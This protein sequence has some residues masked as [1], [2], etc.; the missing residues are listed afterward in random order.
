ML[1]VAEKK[2]KLRESWV[3]K[4][5]RQERKTREKVKRREGEEVKTDLLIGK[6][7]EKELS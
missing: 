2:E 3:R 4:G 1:W 6:D 5:E 7:E